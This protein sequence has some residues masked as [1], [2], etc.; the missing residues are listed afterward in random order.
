V[1]GHLPPLL[2]P[3][4]LEAGASVYYLERQVWKRAEA[5]ELHPLLAPRY[6]RSGSQVQVV[7]EQGVQ[8]EL[9]V[10]PLPL[11]LFHHPRDLQTLDRD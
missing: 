3:H 5:A 9:P 1:E 6:L 11:D 2:L 4:L 7:D 10:L 8:E